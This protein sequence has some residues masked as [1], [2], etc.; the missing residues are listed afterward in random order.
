MTNPDTELSGGCV[1][2]HSPEEAARRAGCGRTTIFAAIKS[3][4]LRAKK[5]GR[6]TR[7]LDQDLKAWLESLPE[8]AA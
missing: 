1:L 8:R 2:A 5:L 6:L 3:G 7:I 4:E